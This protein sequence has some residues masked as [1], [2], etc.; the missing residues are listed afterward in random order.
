MQMMDMLF[1]GLMGG[2]FLEDY[3]LRKEAISLIK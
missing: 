3:Q 2:C 1:K